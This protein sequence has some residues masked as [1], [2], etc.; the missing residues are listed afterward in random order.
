MKELEIVLIGLGL[1]MDAFAVSVASGIILKTMKF[2]H[3][4]RIAAFFGFF[5]ALMPIL[6]WLAGLSFRVYIQAFDHWIAFGLLG[7]IGGKMIWDSLHCGDEGCFDPLDFYVLF[8]LSIATSID[9]L[10]VGLTFSVLNILIWEAAVLIGAVTFA[11]CLA[12]T[13]IG[14]RF[15]HILEKKIEIAGGI[16][17]I[18]LGIKIL[19]EHLFFL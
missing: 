16:I 14:T 11:V 5:Q 17:L 7:F 6:G 9:A 12:G 8:S 1:A 19:I 2:R 13:Y 15:G 3:A 4:F 18:G 10:A